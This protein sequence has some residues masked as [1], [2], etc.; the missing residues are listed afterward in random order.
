MGGGIFTTSGSWTGQSL[1]HIVIPS[2]LGAFEKLYTGRSQRLIQDRRF[3]YFSRGPNNNELCQVLKGGP[4]PAATASPGN[5]LEML[6]P[7]APEPNSEC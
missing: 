2:V 3:P 5:L 6:V 4:K 1:S 7:R